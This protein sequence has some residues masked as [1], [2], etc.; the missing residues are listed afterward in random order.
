MKSI[1]GKGVASLLLLVFLTSCVSSTRVSFNTD[2][3]GAEVYVDGELIGTTPT[4]KK[5]SNAIWEDP[6]V[7]IKKDGYKDLRTSVY[8]EMKPVNLVCGLLLWWPSLLYVYGPKKAQHYI[9]TPEN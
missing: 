7:L 3:E 2:V 4:Q 8:Q 5:L 1:F 6:D 9:L